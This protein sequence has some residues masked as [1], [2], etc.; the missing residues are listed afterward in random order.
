MNYDDL[1]PKET[2]ETQEGVL[3]KGIV[4]QRFEC[5]FCNVL[6]PAAIPVSFGLVA[7]NCPNCMLDKHVEYHS[8]LVAEEFETFEWS[9]PL[10]AE[11][12]TL[13]GALRSRQ[14]EVQLEFD[15]G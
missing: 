7:I 6:F 15:L 13:Y 14:D 5:T 1:L 12:Q 9:F 8:D 4:Y 10:T 11:E 2:K 3:A